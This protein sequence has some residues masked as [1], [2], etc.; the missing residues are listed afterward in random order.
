L[1]K[2][3]NLKK[4][5]EKFILFIPELSCVVDDNNLL[6]AYEKLNLKKQE[7]FG[8]MISLGLFDEIKRPAS[9]NLN[10]TA[11]NPLFPF[12]VKAIIACGVTFIIAFTTI[13]VVHDSVR[14]IMPGGPLGLIRNQ[15]AQVKHGLEEMNADEKKELLNKIHQTILQIKPFTDELSILFQDV[16]PKCSR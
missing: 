15:V 11:V 6:V 9:F 4:N 2:N 13:Y 16:S 10:A 12:V 14:Q 8:D 3:G 7:I 1:Q 5:E